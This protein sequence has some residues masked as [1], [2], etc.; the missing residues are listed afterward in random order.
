MRREIASRLLWHDA[1]QG[2]A[3]E[4]GRL[5]KRQ[6]SI[7]AERECAAQKQLVSPEIDDL[8][9]APLYEC[10][11]FV[12]AAIHE[13]P[14]PG[15][16]CCGN[17]V[18]RAKACGGA[19]R[20]LAIQGHD[21]IFALRR[22]LLAYEVGEGMHALLMLCSLV[23]DL[24]GRVAVIEIGDGDRHRCVLDKGWRPR[25]R[26]Y[27]GKKNQQRRTPVCEIFRRDRSQVLAPYSAATSKTS[28]RHHTCDGTA[29]IGANV[30]VGSVPAARLHGNYAPPLAKLNVCVLSSSYLDLNQQS[31]S[32]QFHKVSAW[33]PTMKCS[34]LAAR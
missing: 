4:T 7:A 16:A 27:G 1:I 22:K 17:E 29:R 25:G 13:K 30:V 2:L 12:N 20:L 23:R 33:A 24:A 8:N 15:V 5:P 6:I 26:S 9:L 11:H 14:R 18:I 34:S 31:I 21:P 10:A 3:D 28:A 19:F 32:Q